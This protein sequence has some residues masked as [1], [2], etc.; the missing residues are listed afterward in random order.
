MKK[1]LRLKGFGNKETHLIPLKNIVDIHFTD[2]FTSIT[3][4]GG[5]KVNV[6]ENE[7]DIMEMLGYFQFDSIS[8]D[9]LWEAYN[10]PF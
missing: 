7:S 4:I 2:D 8:V 3:L 6:N 9:D 10:P 1:F 5:Y